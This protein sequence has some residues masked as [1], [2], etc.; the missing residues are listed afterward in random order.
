MFEAVQ[1]RETKLF[2][3][4]P[5]IRKSEYGID[6]PLLSNAHKKPLFP[7]RKKFL[8]TFSGKIQDFLVFRMVHYFI[9]LTCEYV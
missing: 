8:A 9:H 3:A 5:I 1:K 2:S 6:I 7:L 4:P